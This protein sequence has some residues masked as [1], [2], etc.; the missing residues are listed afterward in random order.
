MNNKTPGSQ[1][2]SGKHPRK[3]IRSVEHQGARRGLS[4]SCKLAGCGAFPSV[5]W[6]RPFP[7]RLHAAQVCPVPKA[8]RPVG[9][10][11]AAASKT[12]TRTITT[13][14]VRSASPTPP[15]SRQDLRR[16]VKSVV[17]VVNDRM[18]SHTGHAI[19]TSGRNTPSYS[20]VPVATPSG[21]ECHGLP[22]CR[23]GN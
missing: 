1:T 12:E 23:G 15:C 8:P 18:L 22:F 9:M 13:R 7:E 5:L 21:G 6:G 20:T 3:S 16:L 17:H 10:C 19:N 11:K 14:D 4:G 2:T